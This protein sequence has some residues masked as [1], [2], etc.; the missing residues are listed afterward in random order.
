MKLIST[1]LL[2]L[3]F[4]A[5]VLADEIRVPV[6]TQNDAVTDKPEHSMSK[7]AV[8]EKYGAPESRHGPN[9]QPPIYFW[10]YPKF[11]VY[12]EGDRVIHSV[13]KYKSKSAMKK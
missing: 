2:S 10:E 11:T 8:E 6:G 13:S 5:A 12:F 9:G 3:S 7:A 4:S 1:L